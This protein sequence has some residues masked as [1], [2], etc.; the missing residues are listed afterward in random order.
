VQIIGPF[1]GFRATQA[2][3]SKTCLVRFDNDKYSVAQRAVGRPVEI[4][5]YADRLVIRQDGAI[6]GE[7]R[8]PLRA[9]ATIYDP[10]HYVPVLARKP[11][12]LTNG[13]AFKD[14]LLPASLE[15][16]RRKLKGSEDGDRQIVEVLSAVLTEGLVV[17]E[18]ACTEALA[19]G[20][21]SDDVVLNI[22]SRL[23][24]PGPVANTSRRCPNSGCPTSITR[25][26]CSDI[27]V[28]CCVRRC[29]RCN[30]GP[31]PSRAQRPSHRSHR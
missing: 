9:R 31:R 14:W 30:R 15:R 29:R 17:V 23:R 13:A 22:L 8:H 28:L 19:H 10:W 27:V 3:V 16:V 21:H 18:T 4:Q 26:S 2:S 6:G 5:A 24:D 20:V 25:I 7:H 1:D 12:A 11:G